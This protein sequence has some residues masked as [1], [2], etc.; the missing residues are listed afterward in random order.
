MNIFFKNSS[1]LSLSLTHTLTH[2]H[3]TPARKASGEPSGPLPHMLVVNVALPLYSTWTGSQVDGPSAHMFMYFRLRDD[4]AKQQM[5][6]DS[7][8]PA[9]Q[10]RACVC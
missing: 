1:S 10:V 3:T 4:A 7:A 2:S 6:E 8:P 5:D 9:L